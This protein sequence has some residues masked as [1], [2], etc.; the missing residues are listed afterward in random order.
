VIL[1]VYLRFGQNCEF[2]IPDL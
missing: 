1:F 2:L